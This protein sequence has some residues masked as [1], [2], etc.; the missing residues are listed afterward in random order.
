LPRIE[1]KFLIDANGILHVSAREQRS[2]KE[3]EIEVKPT[4]GLTDEQVEEMILSSFDHAEEDIRERQVIEAKNEAETILGAVEKGRKHEAWQ[5]LTSDEIE[6]IK[7]REDELKASVMGGDYK[8]IRAAIERLDQATRRFAELMMD[9]AV[10][11]ALGGKTMEA[12]GE[13]I[14]EGP[15]APHPFAKAD[16]DTSS[17]AEREAE[18]IE[19]STKDEETPGESTED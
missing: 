5:Q 9:S 13:S 17:E 4:Y 15:T 10:T 1:V 8:V 18:R 11:G 3:A 14:G 19:D 6:K 12:A 7:Q 2:G 16:I